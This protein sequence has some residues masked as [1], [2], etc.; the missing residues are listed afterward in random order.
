MTQPFPL[1]PQAVAKHPKC[2][3]CAG[4]R[5][6]AGDLPTHTTA[7]AGGKIWSIRKRMIHDAMKLPCESRLLDAS[8]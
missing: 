4:F 5:T 8:N 3:T 6:A 2:W 1:S 7:I